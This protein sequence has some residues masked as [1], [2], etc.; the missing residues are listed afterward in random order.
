[1]KTKNHSNTAYLWLVSPN[2]NVITY[3]YRD[4]EKQPYRMVLKYKRRYDWAA[5]WLTRMGYK[6]KTVHLNGLKEEWESYGIEC[7]HTRG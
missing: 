1:M 3:G 6:Y 2:S 7:D 4:K 5:L